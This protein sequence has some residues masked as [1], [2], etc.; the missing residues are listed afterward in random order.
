MQLKDQGS[1]AIHEMHGLF[2]NL[3]KIFEEELKH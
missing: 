3:I 2:T 1:V